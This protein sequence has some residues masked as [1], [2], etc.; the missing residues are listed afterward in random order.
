M[1]LTFLFQ[2]IVESFSVKLSLQFYHRFLKD[3]LNDIKKQLL[4]VRVLAIIYNIVF[5]QILL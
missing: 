3:D 2:L 5:L 1:T 4:P